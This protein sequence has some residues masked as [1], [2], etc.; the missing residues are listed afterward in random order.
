M[1]DPTPAEAEMT[2][3]T[4]TVDHGGRTY[5]LPASLD[6]VDGDVLDAIDNEKLSHA[7]QGLL[8]PDQWAAFKATKPKVR[9][10]GELFDLFAEKV[11]LYSL[12]E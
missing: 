10:Y 4:V 5:E 2:A 6:D 11:G 8:G 3:E 7:L 1:S 9:D 12:G